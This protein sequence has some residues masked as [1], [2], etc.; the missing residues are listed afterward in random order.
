MNQSTVA[1][2]TMHRSEEKLRTDRLLCA[3]SLVRFV[4]AETVG[5]RAFPRLSL[6]D[7]M[8]KMLFRKNYFFDFLLLFFRDVLLRHVSFPPFWIAEERQHPTFPESVSRALL[9]P[10]AVTETVFI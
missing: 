8:S 3:L 5:R 10:P 6:T 7:S 9:Q 4:C 1:A 2:K